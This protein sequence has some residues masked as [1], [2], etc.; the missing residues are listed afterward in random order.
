MATKTTVKEVTISTPHGKFT[1]PS[2]TSHE[3]KGKTYYRTHCYNSMA[4][5]ISGGCEFPASKSSAGTC[6]YFG[7]PVVN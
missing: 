2:V 7:V 1:V 5:E 3:Y 4:S 6:S